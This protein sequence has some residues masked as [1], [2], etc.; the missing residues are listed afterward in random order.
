[1]KSSNGPRLSKPRALKLNKDTSDGAAACINIAVGDYD[2]T[3]PL[4]N[5]SVHV[6][7]FNADFVAGD[8]EEIF[9]Q[10]FG[11][12]PF[13]VTELSFSNFLISSARGNCPYLA[14]PIFPSRSFRHSAIYLRTDAGISSPADLK[15]KRIGTREYS[16]T[17]SLVV[18][19]ILADEYDYQPETSDWLVGDID[20]LERQAIDT[21]N[22]PT[23]DVSI[24]AVEGRT[25]SS[26]L[27]AGEVDA[28]ISY[29]PP[30]RF[31]KDT[32]M[33]RLF[34]D[35]RS[36]EQD[37]F[38]RT[39]RFPVMHI[40]GIRKDTL[41]ENPTLPRALLKAFEEAKQL[42]QARLAVHQALPVMLPWMTAEAQATQDLMGADFWKYGLEA[43]QDILSTQIRWS[44]DQGLIPR[45]PDLSELFAAV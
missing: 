4:L 44:F 41:T 3:A 11:S 12:A 21:K 39:R 38:R 34:P 5:G 31:G 36:A 37:Y 16:N 29:T 8:L 14:L 20:H 35:W 15:G 25:L 42:A 30:D 43:N 13:A 33:V 22:W 17:L 27:A 45:R 32:S 18:R 23:N 19:G 6:A 7:G 1:M 10:A 24:K 26:L 28:L 40:M 2:R 9:A